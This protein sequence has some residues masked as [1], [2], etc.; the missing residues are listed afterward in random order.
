VYVDTETTGLAG[1]TGTYAFL[2]GV[3]VHEEGGFVVDQVVLPGPEHERGYLIAVRERLA[4]AAAV[5][6]YNGASFDLPLLRTRFALHGID[7]PLAGVPHLDLLPLARR[8]W[9]DRLPDCRLGTI[10]E[11]V[12]GARRS[13]RDVPGAEVPARYRAFLR[14][15]DAHGLRGVLEHNRDDVVALSA[16]R[17]WL[18]LRSVPGVSGDPDEVLAWARWWE[19]AGDSATALAHLAGIEDRH[20]DAAWHA[21]RL[22]RRA[23]RTDEALAR[24]RRLADVDDA[25]GWIELA[26]HHEHRTGDLSAALTAAEAAG[27]AGGA[28]YDDLERRLA[29]LRARLQRADR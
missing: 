28:A 24:W 27:R 22:L 19:A 17:S 10:E 21:G 7:D 13:A 12:L 25:R 15:R 23:G 18:E 5:V 29:R 6:S 20:D 11:H 16:L 1:G 4:G 8:L 9:R 26:K 2:V 14:S 3:G